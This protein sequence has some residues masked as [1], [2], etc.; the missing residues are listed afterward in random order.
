MEVFEFLG[1]GGATFGEALDSEILSLVVSKAKIVLGTEEIFLGLL[2]VGDGFVD[3]VDGGLEFATG[4][5]VITG[6]AGFE[7][8]HV[9]LEVGNVDILVLDGN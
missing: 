3:F 5:F 9:F 8:F 1:H 6:K 7:G 4:E 2:K